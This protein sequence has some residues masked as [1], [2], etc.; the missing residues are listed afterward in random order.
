MSMTVRDIKPSLLWMRITNGAGDP[1]NVIMD[2]EPD[3]LFAI[4]DKTKLLPNT[5]GHLRLAENDE[6]VASLIVD[7]LLETVDWYRKDGNFQD[8]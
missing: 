7:A 6:A 8:G 1:S 4:K 3:L 2:L 5:L